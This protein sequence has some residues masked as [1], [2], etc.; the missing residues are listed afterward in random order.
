MVWFKLNRWACTGV[1][2]NESVATSTGGNLP[3]K[4]DSKTENLLNKCEVKNMSSKWMLV[5]VMWA[6]SYKPM[7][8]NALLIDFKRVQ[9][10]F[11]V[12]Q[13][14]GSAL[15][16][17]IYASVQ[18]KN[19]LSGSNQTMM[20]QFYLICKQWA[21]NYIF[22]NGT[23]ATPHRFNKCIE[24]QSFPFNWISIHICTRWMRATLL[25]NEYY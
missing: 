2:W 22:G 3:F 5:G 21:N 17:F 14:K 7:R 4:L 1:A 6:N 18:F 8:A 24:Y 23:I 10:L 12:A 13:T 19:G 16:P 25:N 20:A 9:R 11:Q 15:F